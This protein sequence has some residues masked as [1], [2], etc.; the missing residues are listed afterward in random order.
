M[1]QAV[2]QDRHILRRK[3]HSKESELDARIIELQNDIQEFQTKLQA[4]DNL[5][6]QWE[7]EKTSLV[8]ELRSQNARLT[9]QLKETVAEEQKLRAELE[10]YREQV[11]L[12]K[13]NLQVSIYKH[14][15]LWTNILKTRVDSNCFL[16]R[17]LKA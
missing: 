8:T 2:E 10:G 12:G 14:L 5:L 17:Q 3:L 1:F 4:K 15:R 11:A 16:W 9:Q 7:K 6:K 13:N